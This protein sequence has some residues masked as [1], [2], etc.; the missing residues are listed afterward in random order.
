MR[1]EAWVPRQELSQ[2]YMLINHQA[3]ANANDN[4]HCL[5]QQYIVFIRS[6]QRFLDPQCL[7]RP[8][9]GRLV[10]RCPCLNLRLHPHLFVYMAFL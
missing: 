5:F 1:L 10:G 6:S 4:A 8:A 7:L 2:A 9:T 3:A